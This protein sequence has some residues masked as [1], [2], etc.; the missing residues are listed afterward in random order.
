MIDIPLTAAAVDQ[1]LELLELMG[2]FGLLLL[3]LTELGGEFLVGTSESFILRLEILFAVFC[4]H[5]HYYTE[6]QDELKDS[7]CSRKPSASSSTTNVE[8]SEQCSEL[9]KLQLDA[10]AP[11]VLWYR[12]GKRPLLKT[13][14][15]QPET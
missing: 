7:A 3:E 12:P 11:V 1:F 2:E 8:T 14:V 10:D 4:I 13:L 6:R 9:R 5:H 15:E